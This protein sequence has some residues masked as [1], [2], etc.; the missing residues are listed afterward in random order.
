MRILTVFPC[1][2]LIFLFLSVVIA[3]LYF[4]LYIRDQQKFMQFWGLAWLSFAIGLVIVF[5]YLTFPSELLLE[6]RR[7]MDM[8]NS[9][10]LLVGVFSFSHQK[11]PG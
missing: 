4:Y 2:L 3:C 8:L 10:L 1:I 6:L 9:V 11:M 7:L 5:F